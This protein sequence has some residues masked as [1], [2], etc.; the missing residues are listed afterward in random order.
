MEAQDAEEFPD[1]LNH[2]DKAIELNILMPSSQAAFNKGVVYTK[3]KDNLN[4]VRAYQ[5]ALELNPEDEKP[6]K[7][8]ERLFL[9]VKNC[10]GGGGEG[11]NKNQ[12]KNQ[13]KNKNKNK[14]KS[15]K[16]KKQGDDKKDQQDQQDPKDQG[17]QKDQKPETGQ[18]KQNKKKQPKEFKSQ[19]LSKSDVMKI[20]EELKN[21]E[22]LIR[23]KMVAPR[24]QRMKES[25]SGKD[26]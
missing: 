13:D 14:S 16:D 4:A 10:K 25:P 3:L 5:K 8:L 24:N 20:L 21:Q 23:M 1:A 15:G 17:K 19:A 11:E 2:Y 18:E 6:R 22:N 7:N 26:W 12:D 9:D